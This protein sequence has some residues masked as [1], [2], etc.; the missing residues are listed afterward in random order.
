MFSSESCVPANIMAEVFVAFPKL[1]LNLNAEV[2]TPQTCAHCQMF[3]YTHCWEGI[4]SV[5]SDGMLQLATAMDYG[6]DGPRLY[7]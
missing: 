3:I 2:S 7:E 4:D 1:G 6:V 5:R